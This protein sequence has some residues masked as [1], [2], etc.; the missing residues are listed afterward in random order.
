MRRRTLI[1]GLAAAVA[2]A[3]GVA[4]CTADT[5]ADAQA[6]ATRAPSPS[7]SLSVEPSV[8]P[9]LAPILS[10]TFASSLAPRSIGDPYTPVPGT[11]PTRAYAVG[12]KVYPGF[13][14][15][16]GRPLPTTVWYPATGDAPANG[17]D[18]RE[19]A[20]AATGQFPLVLFSHGLT[21]QPSDYEAML[22]RWAQ[23]GFVVAGP[24]YPFTHYQAT[25][26][27]QTD[28]VHQPA[29][30][31]S[32][33]D[34]LL[35]LDVTTD[36]VRA[37]I[38]QDRIGAT[39][40]SAGGITTVGLFSEFRDTRLKCGI[41]LDG[42]DFQGTPFTGP[43]AAMLFIHGKKDTTVSWSAG[44]TVFEAVPW[45]RA[46]LTITKGGHVTTAASFEATTRTSTQFLRY[47][48]WGDPTAKTAIPAAA[49]AGH[50]ATIDDQL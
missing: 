27:D 26:F 35:A 48:L 6:P 21:S 14:R 18:P 42:T 20:S 32:V 15:G 49:A 9:S 8:K 12:R 50:V 39:G 40:H 43:S 22:S 31:S 19:G 2:G 33:L 38:D 28:I 7:P 29:D 5:D 17:P 44:R 25:G 16:A 36:P 10:S 37:I 41:V 1:F 47:A 11:A 46:M 3:G 45:S 23:A 34:Q 4:G 13:R 24:T 30:A